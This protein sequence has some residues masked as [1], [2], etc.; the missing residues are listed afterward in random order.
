M[1]RPLVERGGEREKGKAKR[2]VDK[3]LGPPFHSTWCASDPDASSYWQEHGLLTGL[4]DIGF[5]VG[6]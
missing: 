6:T 2:P 3:H 4:I 1:N 5:L